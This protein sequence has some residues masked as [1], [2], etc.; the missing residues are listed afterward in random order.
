MRRGGDGPSLLPGVD[1][2]VVWSVDLDLSD[3]ELAPLGEH[4]SPDEAARASRFVFDVHRRRFVAGR[5]ALREILGRG[6]G[7][8]PA[9]V[10]FEYGPQGKP[11][12]GGPE[13]GSGL[14][15]N[16]SH[17]A[18]LALVAVTSRRE[19]GVDVEEVRDVPDAV[20]IAAR[21]FSKEENRAFLSVPAAE[22]VAVFFNAWTRKE[23]YLKAL[24]DGLAHPLDA[25]DVTLLANEPARLLRVRGNEREAARWSLWSLDPAPGFVGAIV[26]ETLAQAPNWDLAQGIWRDVLRGGSL[27]S[28]RSGGGRHLYGPRER[29]SAVFALAGRAGTSR[30]MGIVRAH[31]TESGVPGLGAGRL[32]GSAAGEPPASTLNRPQSHV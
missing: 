5:G 16:V 17:S 32:D 7:V 4:L 27:D 29:R 28:G 18:G 8:A 1:E 2:V 13:A 19:I 22:R 9:R 15:F 14:Q 24:G 20:P 26:V 25:F 12:L 31:G 11:R 6:L 21:C 10:C 3:A 23:A 30:G